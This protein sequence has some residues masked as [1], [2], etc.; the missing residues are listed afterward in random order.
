MTDNERSALSRENE[1][2]TDAE[3]AANV[4][5]IKCL[6]IMAVLI[7]LCDILNEI[8][9]FHVP[10]F[11]MRA[12]AALGCII[13]LCP[14]IVLLLHDR[15][16]K[17]TPSV[18]RDPKFRIL[19]TVIA[20][21]GVALLGI[22]L[23]NH[24]VVVLALPSLFAAQYREQKKLFLLVTVL[25]VILVPLTVYGS[26]FFGSADRN[27]L[28][29]VLS[30]GE[31]ADLSLRLSLAT[32][33]RMAELFYHHALPRMIGVL[34]INMLASGISR[35]NDKMLAKQAELDETVRREMERENE[36][37]GQVIDGMAS[38]IETR[39][40]ST[41]DH[42]KR[43]KHYVTLLVNE[44]RKDPKYRDLLSDE[45]SEMIS[46]A[47]PLHDIGKI[48][49]SD[50]ILLK[51]GK[52]TAE[53]FEKMKTHT[54]EGRKMIKSVFGSMDNELFKKTAEDIAVSHHEKWD[55]SGYPN[56]ASGED[57]PLSARIMAVADVYDA[58]VSERVYKKPIPAEQ[59]FEI[60][61]SESGS[62]FDPDVVDAMMR[63]KDEFTAGAENV[64]RD[65]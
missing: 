2:Y 33:K 41:G 4:F 39:D 20:Y 5:N 58:L 37:Q 17:K 11:I 47:A 44:M 32:P 14:L 34:A 24:A 35:R 27:L 55:G 21:C 65:K 23:S 10:P 12:S 57:I 36:M 42:V 59:A 28:K 40:A 50:T 1:L 25:T 15:L 19:I 22:S 63:I 8:D 9:V 61:K 26:F 7:V 6:S 48:T 49:V 45:N 29:V 62:H 46:S 16:L 64:P 52:L 60:I 43:T 18:T 54:T 3:A 38:V 30:D 53:E 51:P 13:F 31:A 56:A